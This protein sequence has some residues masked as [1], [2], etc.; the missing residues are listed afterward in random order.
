LVGT[1]CNWNHKTVLGSLYWSGSEWQKFPNGRPVKECDSVDWWY[2]YNWDTSDWKNQP[3]QPHEVRCKK[4][5]WLGSSDEM[6][7]GPDF[8]TIQMSCP[9]CKAKNKNIDWIDYDPN[10]NIGYKNQK[11]YCK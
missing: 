1:P 5:N 11:K 10:T 9:V 2:G 8:L 3:K 6:I 7:P 4:C